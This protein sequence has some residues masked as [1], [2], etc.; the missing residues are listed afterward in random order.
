MEQCLAKVNTCSKVEKI[1][2][3]VEIYLWDFE[4]SQASD[5]SEILIKKLKCF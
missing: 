4:K 5:I 2:P 3:D 1:I